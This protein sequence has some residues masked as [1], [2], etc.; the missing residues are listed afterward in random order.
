[1]NILISESHLRGLLLAGLDWLSSR[2]VE[3]TPRF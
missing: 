3:C 1:M 2:A